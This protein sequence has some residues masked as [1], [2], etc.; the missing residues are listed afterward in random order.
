ME[1][2]PV[3]TALTGAVVHAP[4]TIAGVLQLASTDPPPSLQFQAQIAQDGVAIVGV[5]VAQ[6]FVVGA[7]ATAVPVAVPQADADTTA[8]F[9]LQFAF[10]PLLALQLHFHDPATLVAQ[11]EDPILQSDPFGGAE[12]YPPP[13]A[14]PQVADGL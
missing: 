9:A 10:V 13:F 3:Y 8:I 7:V 1:S 6:R 5:P 11:V 4:L 2:P 12:R 14:I